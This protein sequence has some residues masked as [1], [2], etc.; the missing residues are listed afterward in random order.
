MI[1]S[2]LEVQ[3]VHHQKTI[4]RDHTHGSM[5]KVSMGTYVYFKNVG[6]AEGIAM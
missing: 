3:E 1:G 6:I 2:P 5:G 4:A